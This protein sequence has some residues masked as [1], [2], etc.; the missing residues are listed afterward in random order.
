MRACVCDGGV[1][2][3]H[4]VPPWVVATKNAEWMFTPAEL[5]FSV[6]KLTFGTLNVNFTNCNPKLFCSS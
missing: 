2:L 4:L 3:V 5:T 1:H 6:A